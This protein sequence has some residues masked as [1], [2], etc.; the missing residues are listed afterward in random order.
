MLNINY[1]TTPPL[2]AKT[3]HRHVGL[4]RLFKEGVNV[5]QEL[6]PALDR[7]PD[8]RRVLLAKQPRLAPLRVEM[9]VGAEEGLKSASLRRRVV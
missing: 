2:S 1:M 5:R 6:V 4:R 8:H 9:R 7:R 3:Y